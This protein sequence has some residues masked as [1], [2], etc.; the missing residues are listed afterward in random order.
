MSQCAIWKR[1]SIGLDNCV[2]RSRRSAIF[3]KNDDLVWWRIYTSF[4]LDELK[5]T[6]WLECA[7]F[8]FED[9]IKWKLFSRYWPFVRGIHWSPVNSPHKGQWCGALV[10]SSNC[11]WINCWVNNREAGDL[12]RHR[13][14]YD[15]TVKSKDLFYWRGLAETWTCLDRP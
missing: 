15:A 11:T 3:W 5:Y 12:G 4:I 1:S 2:V 14:Q 10:F 13:T 9:Y 7:L 6:Y 8:Y